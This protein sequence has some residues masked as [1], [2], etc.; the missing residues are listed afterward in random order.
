MAD[1]TQTIICF[2]CGGTA[3]F[4]T[5]KEGYLLYR[6]NTCG[7]GMISPLPH[8]V[9]A[10]YGEDYFAGAEEGFGY[11]DYDTDKEPM[12]P[13]FT[14][15][16]RQAEQLLGSKGRVLDVGAATGFFVHLAKEEGWR[17]AGVEI[18]DFA[19]ALGRAKGLAVQTGTL[20]SVHFEPESFDLITLWDVIE[21]VFDP[22]AELGR[23]RTL[24]RSGGIL[25]MTTPDFSSRYAK[26]LGRRWHAIVPPEHLYYFTN[27][28]MRQMLIDGGF[29]IVS[30]TAPIKTF[31]LSY[32]FQMLSRWQGE[33]LWG[34]AVT[35]LRKYPRVGSL[36]LPIP[37]RD[38]I[39]VT[40]RRQ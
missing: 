28:S 40:A 2:V 23:V 14:K 26:L 34:W 24:L 12:R 7:Q 5:E 3:T 4:Y 15:V 17:A 39:L 38:N 19:A 21:H 8:T 1:T 32:I 37:I 11:V 29:E 13:L 22:V 18:S 35:F 25:Q 33:K 6:C 9:D 10:V 36:P 31:T 20:E 16:L 30:M 27:R